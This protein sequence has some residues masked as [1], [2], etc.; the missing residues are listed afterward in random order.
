MLKSQ[1]C[2]QDIINSDIA[3][4]AQLLM[5]FEYHIAIFSI[6]ILL[7]QYKKVDP[8]HRLTVT[9]RDLARWNDN[10]R[11]PINREAYTRKALEK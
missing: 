1:G 8:T 7:H 6:H 5:F 11:A 3:S 10:C 2:Q 9:S 4:Y